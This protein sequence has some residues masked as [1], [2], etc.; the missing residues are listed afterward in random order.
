MSTESVAVEYVVPVCFQAFTYFWEHLISEGCLQKLHDDS[1]QLLSNWDKR[2][3][4][5]EQL[6]EILD[7]SLRAHFKHFGPAGERKAG[8]VSL[9][10]LGLL[11][12]VLVFILRLPNGSMSSTHEL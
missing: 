6:L 8:G 2:F 3:S 11:G 5:L 7:G 9:L 10:S 4:I 1:L 12:S